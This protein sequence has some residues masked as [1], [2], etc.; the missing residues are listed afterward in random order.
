[1]HDFIQDNVNAGANYLRQQLDATGGN[2]IEAIGAYNG[3]FRDMTKGY[4]CSAKGKT[5]GLPQNLDYLQETLNGWFTGQDPYGGQYWIGTYK[6]QG[7][8]NGG[9]VC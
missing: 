2:A 3:W 7:N 5:N 9:N 6:C 4:P 1:M 8:C